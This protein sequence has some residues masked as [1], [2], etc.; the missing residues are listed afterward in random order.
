M[1]FCDD[2]SPCASVSTLF[3]KTSQCATV[4]AQIAAKCIVVYAKCDLYIGIPKKAKRK[5]R[6]EVH[7][8]AI[9]N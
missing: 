4:E 3:L 1:R 6:F 9:E 5:M 8:M 2:V 7:I